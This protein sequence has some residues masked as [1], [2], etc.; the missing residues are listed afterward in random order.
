MWHGD[1]WFVLTNLI[2][3]DFKI[4]YRNMSLGPLW[5]ILNPLVLM[6]VLT[7]VFTRIFHNNSIPHFGVFIMCG[8]VPYNFFTLAWLSGTTSLTDSAGLIKRVMVPREIIPLAAVLSNCLHLLIQIGLLFTMLF[9]FAIPPNRHWI[10]LP[11]IWVLEVIFVFG[12]SLI[13]S[14][15]N[16][17]VRDIRYIVESAN[18][19]LFWLAPI[20]YSFSVIP[21]SYKGLYELNPLAALVMAMRNILLDGIQPPTRLLFKL[22]ISSL[23]IA[24]LGL[25]VFRGLKE[26]FYDYL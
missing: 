26:K 18:V 22:A 21:Q 17:C 14:S 15:L 3:K 11:V 1:Y 2:T 24:G 23:C 20:F 19:V 10:W 25:V 8:L 16:V 4:R 13:T 7:F 12:L 6:G 9:L 5:S